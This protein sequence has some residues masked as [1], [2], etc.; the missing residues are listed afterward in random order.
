MIRPEPTFDWNSLDK[1]AETI[2]DVE[3]GFTA[4]DYAARYEL[5]D[6]TAR[7]QLKSLERQGKIKRIGYRGRG[8]QREIVWGLIQEDGK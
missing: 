3:G 7:G 6:S 2:R 8:R 5:P 1:L 4:S